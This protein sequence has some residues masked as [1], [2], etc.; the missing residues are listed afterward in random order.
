MTDVFI[1]GMVVGFAIAAPVGPVGLLCFRRALADGRV[2][3]LIAG[4]GAAAADTF[5]GAVAAY[6]LHFISDFLQAHRA[7]VT[8]VG[9][10]FLCLIGWRTLCSPPPTPEEAKVGPGP[11]RDFLAT[12]VITL[13]NP[14]TIIAFMGG[15]ALIGSLEPALIGGAPH[16]LVIGVFAGSTLWWT[17]LSGGAAAVR[18]R[19]TAGWLAQVNRLAGMA[20]LAFGVS[21]LASLAL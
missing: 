20:I 16:V 9:G 2:A 13:T 18:S 6:G 17:I 5:Y 7:G 21:V 15:F 3:A 1:R 4:L 14:G 12:F 10:I 11:V 8:L 19:L